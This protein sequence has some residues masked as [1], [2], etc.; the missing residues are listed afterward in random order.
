VSFMM[1]SQQPHSPKRHQNPPSP[2]MTPIT[3]TLPR[4]MPDQ[5]SRCDAA[6]TRVCVVR[7]PQCT[8]THKH[9]QPHCTRR[10]RLLLTARSRA[11]SLRRRPLVAPC[12]RFT[13][14]P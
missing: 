10:R 11:W 13:P 2:A 5:V 4:P 9:A 1:D 6:A 8:H 14:R 12:P 7:R 3:M